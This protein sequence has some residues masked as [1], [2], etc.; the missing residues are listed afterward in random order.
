MASLRTISSRRLIAGIGGVVVLAVAGVSVGSALQGAN[1]PAPQPLADALHQAAVG[2]KPTGITADVTFT[3]NLLS[4]AGLPGGD[5]LM[6]GAS[7][8]MWI[9]AAG[10]LRI[11]LQSSGGGSPDSQILATK[12][13]ITVYDGTQNTVYKIALPASSSTPKTTTPSNGIPT[14]AAIQS[15][16][17]ELAAHLNVSGAIPGAAG[18]VPSYS[19]KISPQHDGGLLGNAELAWDA[20]NGVPLGVSVYSTTDPSTPVLALR[21]NDISY[22]PVDAS[23]LQ[24][25]PPANAKVVDVPLPPKSTKSSTTTK[26]APVTGLAAVQ[27]QVA[28]TIK[29]PATVDGLPQHQ[30]RLVDW[31]GQKAALVLYGQGLG[32]IAVLERATTTSPP[33]A[34]ITQLPT[35]KV[36]GVSGHEL[37]TPLGT[38][39][40]FTKGGVNFI[41]AGSVSQLAAETAAGA[42]S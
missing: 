24:I 23:A 20:S 6:S 7:G 3:N 39:V 14:V 12:S 21:V 16:L 40:A 37:A 30:V 42:L 34:T 32:G 4:S 27:S 10:D 35:V 26:T 9:S 36:A 8:R 31:K 19:V 22:G 1:P 2:A 41:V 11:E 17:N 13:E 18:G 15:K 38:V 28:F 5:P 33:N 29:A 25:S